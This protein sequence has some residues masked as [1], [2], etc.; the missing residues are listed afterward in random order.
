MFRPSPRLRRRQRTNSPTRQR[1]RYR[2]RLA[3]NEPLEERALL[4]GDLAVDLLP[5]AV[6]TLSSIHGFKFEDVNRN[7][8]Y[9]D[10]VDEPLSGV[11]FEITIPAHRGDPQVV[12]YDDLDE[13]GDGFAEDGFQAEFGG[14]LGLGGEIFVSPANAGRTASWTFEGLTPGFYEVAVTWPSEADRPNSGAQPHAT[15][16]PFSINGETPIP[17]NQKPAPGSFVDDDFAHISWQVID[18]SFEV[19]GGT[20]IVELTDTGADGY[21]IA[22]AVRIA[23]AERFIG[24]ATTDAGGEFQIAGLSPA[25][26]QIAEIIP[27]GWTFTTFPSNRVTVNESEAH[28]WRSG[29][30]MLPT[31][32]PRSEV[33]DGELLM[34]G[35]RVAD[36]NFDFS[37]GDPVNIQPGFIGVETSDLYAPE[38]GYGWQSPPGGAFGWGI[39]VAPLE[40]VLEDG[41]YRLDDG[42]GA[43]HFL[44]DL[45]NGQYTVTALIGDRDFVHDNLQLT[46]EGAV[47]AADIDTNLVEPISFTFQ[48]TIADGQLDFGISDLGG[49]DDINFWVLNGLTISKHNGEPLNLAPA[50]P[51]VPADGSSTVVV[52][53]FTY[54]NDLV[55][56]LV[57]VSTELGTITTADASSEFDGLQVEIQPDGVFE[58]TIRAPGGLTVD[59]DSLIEA[60]LV[61]LS[62][63]DQTS[64]EFRITGSIVGRKFEDL[65]GDGVKDPGE[66]GLNGWTIELVDPDTN[67]V[68]A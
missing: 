3:G 66:P 39:P 45:P 19:T 63:V 42:A 23:P 52:S 10:S 26:Y 68:V 34:F 35:N 53:G 62:G 8:V 41:H 13:A 61:G 60:T 65:N 9:D 47:V 15:N 54:N 27:D 38:V 25:R 40:D 56:H 50:T 20:L 2:H 49:D 28:V 48:T 1:T 44:V 12:D 46:A 33:V 24:T 43:G 5:A 11:D 6:D 64:V 4:A 16:A 7:G 17:V 30:A 21:V 58:F 37:G 18:A 67:S 29:A 51:V 59:T 57:T 55:G 31:G 14:L 32:D 22:D 36:R